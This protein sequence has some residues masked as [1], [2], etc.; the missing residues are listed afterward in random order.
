MGVKKVLTSIDEGFDEAREALEH[1]V[2]V[3]SISADDEN[4]ADVKRS[5]QL[6][7][8]YLSACGLE[9]VRQATAAGCPPAV[10]GEWLHAEDAPTILL[11]AHHDV[12]PPGFVERWTSDPFEPVEREGRLYGRGTADDKAGAVAHGAMIKAWLDTEGALPC[13][14]KV[15]VEGEEEIGSPRLAAFLSEYVD[16]LSADVLL[17]ADAGNWKVGTP[18]LTYS[19]RGLIGADVTVRV[20]DGPAHSGLA[21]GPVPDPVTALARMLASLVDL[22]GDVAIDGFWDDVQP[23]TDE[24]R[25]R[26][27]A[28]PGDTDRLR[29]SWGVLASVELTGDPSTSIYERLWFRPALAVIGFDSHPIEGSSNQIVAE[30]SA[31]IS[32]RV[33]RG[34]DPDRLLDCLRRHLEER[35]PWGLEFAFDA[36]ESV[37]AW[38]CDPEGW[39]FDAAKRALATGFGTDPV[40]MGV[41]G[42]I[43]FVKPFAEAFG[44]IPALLLGPADP[45][46]A[47]HGED[48]SLHLGDWRKLMASEALLL[49]ELATAYAS[50]SSRGNGR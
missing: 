47:I 15:F 23:L 46:S 48:E 12:Q 41:G 28:L 1:L 32:I 43:P 35:I 24:E 26:L 13:N 14:V 29:D 38:S 20:M 44:G 17:L 49:E 33:A 22:R 18:G 5:A 25:A 42:T 34:Q 6:T 45:E 16:D 8:N 7:A 37:P 40:L 11:Y 30:A 27:A 19:L 36:E 3:P 9:N 50:N 2:R 4:A 39:A 10:I 21:G 31:R